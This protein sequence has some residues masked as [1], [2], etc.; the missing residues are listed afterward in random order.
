MPVTPPTCSWT[1]CNLLAACPA[2]NT[3]GPSPTNTTTPTVTATPTCNPAGAYRILIAYADTGGPPTPCERD[4]GRAGASR[5]RPLRRR[6]RHA[7]PGPAPAI[8]RGCRLQQQSLQQ[9]HR[10]GRRA[11]KLCGCGRHRRRHQLRL[12]RPP[13]GLDGRWMTGGYTPF[14][15]YRPH[16]VLQQHSGHVH[17]RPSADAGRGHPQRLLPPQRDPGPRRG[18]GRGLGRQRPAHRLQ[19][20]G[21]PHRH[22]HQQ[23]RG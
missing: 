20:P 17:A 12:V 13:F 4:P 7:D 18:P 5:R 21:G 6:R 14:N 10:H 19:G 23:L 16:P 8:Y 3:P 9:R 1:T 11:G 22:R 2:T 15:S